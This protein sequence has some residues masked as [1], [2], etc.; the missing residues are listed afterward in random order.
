MK[1]SENQETAEIV[2]M[3]NSLQAYGKIFVKSSS[4]DCDGVW[5][6]S[7]HTF[8]SIKEHD[9]A[10]ESWADGL[11]GSAS[12]EMVDEA[13]RLYNEDETGTFGQGWGIN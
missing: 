9:E 12:W 6:Y 11:E 13:N 5:R 8:S 4:Q 3:K 1:Q 2:A 7:N 10:L